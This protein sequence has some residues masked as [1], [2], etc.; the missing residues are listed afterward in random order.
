[1]TGVEALQALRDGKKVTNSDYKPDYYVYAVEYIQGGKK[2]RQIAAV[3]VWDPGPI[4][5]TFWCGGDPVNATDFLR[6]DWE[7]WDEVL[8]EIEDAKQLE[9]HTWDEWKK[10]GYHIIKGQKAESFN[11]AGEALF[12]RLQVDVTLRPLRPYRRARGTYI[13]G[14]SSSVQRSGSYDFDGRPEYGGIG[15]DEDCMVTGDWDSW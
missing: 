4:S 13:F 2:H 3:G 11:T 7:L 14:V 10:L 1:M 9:K 5:P 15:E 6:D 8:Q 12:T